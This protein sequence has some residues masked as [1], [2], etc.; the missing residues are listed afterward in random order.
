MEPV[1]IDKIEAM[2]RS[3][4]NTKEHE[5]GCADCFSVLD[6][7]ME[8]ILEGKNAAEIMP[9]VNDH[10]IRCGDCHEEFEGLLAA[11]HAT[12]EA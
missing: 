12:H 8:L 3:I 11:L 7:F 10:L 5:I 9:L 4:I 2:V 6:T 1:K